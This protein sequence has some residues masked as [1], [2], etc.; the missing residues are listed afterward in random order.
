MLGTEY[1]DTV[2]LGKGLVITEQS[3]AVG[4]LTTGTPLNGAH[5]LN[6][7]DGVLGLG[8]VNLTLGTLPNA[9]TTT[10]TTVTHNLYIQGIIPTELVCI[11]FEPVSPT[12]ITLGQLA[13]GGVDTSRYTGNIAFA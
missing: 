10:I 13:F 12:D 4:S 11:S 5:P 1:T 8:P 9:P 7:A 2:T 3:I 6:G